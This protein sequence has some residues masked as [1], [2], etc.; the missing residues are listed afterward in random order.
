MTPTLEPRSLTFIAQGCQGRLIRG[1][2]QS[3]VRRV[4]TDSKRVEPADLFVAIK[5]ERFDGHDFVS[6]AAC[7][8]AVA[9]MVATDVAPQIPEACAIIQVDDTRLALGRLG[10]AYR[11]DFELPV[12]AVCGSNGK[13]TTKDLLASVLG[14]AMPT[15]AS[16]SSFNNDIGVP[17]TLLNLE[18]RH[19]VAV[20]EVGTNHPGELAP[21][22]GMIRPQ[23]GVLTGIG[24][25]HLEYFG[26]LEGVAREEGM[27]AEV[28]PSHGMLIVNG[29]SPFLDSI[30]ARCACPVVR[31]GLDPSNDWRA[32]E[33]RI[34]ASGMRFRV[35][36]ASAPAFCGEYRLGL[37]GRH[38]VGNALLALAAG[39]HMGVT[40]DQA[41]Q[42]LGQCPPAK[43]RMEPWPYRGALILN[44][45]YNAN[46]E[47]TKS[48]LETLRDVP[49]EWRRVAVLG[50]M[51]ELG[52]HSA[53]SHEEIGRVAA[54]CGIPL[55]I[56]VG[57]WAEHTAAAARTA[58]LSE[59]HVLK[60][61][62]EAA[63]FLKAN[64]REGDLIL[65][66]ASR[67]S[68]FEHIAKLLREGTSDAQS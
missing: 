44:D 5:G 57:T 54:Q 12:V 2:P 53:A 36:Q 58:G 32:T 22:L 23:V 6:D 51:A 45:A 8:R 37:L 25:E 9:V 56:T 21:L 64:I 40:P 43:M 3:W 24:P 35:D 61:T 67:A 19:R 65:L 4:C 29:D 48:A 18:S 7:K 27:L 55:L 38:Q 68:A 59:V 33:I 11:N 16:A 14:Q 46:V 31:A 60:Q 49:G 30:E 39:A 52:A 42:G 63:A 47:S 28:L 26:D 41:R 34:E 20:L 15:L 1:S 10:A 17:L 66:K 62:A 13:T 50:D